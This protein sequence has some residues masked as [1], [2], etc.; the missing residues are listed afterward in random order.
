MESCARMSSHGRKERICWQERKAV[1]V[2]APRF[3]NKL[4]AESTGDDD[5]DEE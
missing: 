4:L 1:R 3:V 2:F 5:D